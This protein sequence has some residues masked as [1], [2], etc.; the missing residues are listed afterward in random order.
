MQQRDAAPNN[1]LNITEALF[2]DR[3]TKNLFGIKNTLYH[4][5]QKEY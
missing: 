3:F 2:Y 5:S 1:A 4:N